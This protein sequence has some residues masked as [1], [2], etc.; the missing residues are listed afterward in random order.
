MK[1]QQPKHDKTN[2]IIAIDGPAGSGKSTTAKLVATK[3]GFTFLDTGALYRAVTLEALE[4][5]LD[6]EDEETLDLLISSTEFKLQAAGNMTRVWSNSKEITEEIRSLEVTNNVSLVSKHAKVR[7][8]MVTLQRKIASAGNYVVEGR[9]IGTVVFPHAQLKVFLQ[10][11][12][13][14]RT[15]RRKLE[16]EKKGTMVSF[17]KLRD[18]IVARD[19]FDSERAV[20]PLKKAVDAFVLDTTELTIEQQVDKIVGMYQQTVH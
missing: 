9:D 8:A 4:K 6:L 16:L 10:A 20:A 17:T 12:L 13:K 7:H 1:I 14:A 11:S 18:E 3:L 19:K 5:R 15:T 2:E